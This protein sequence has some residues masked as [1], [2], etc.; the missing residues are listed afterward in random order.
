MDAQRKRDIGIAVFIVGIFA[1][2]LMFGDWPLLGRASVGPVKGVVVSV[3]GSGEGREA[4]VQLDQ[5]G[6]VRAT[7]SSGCLVLPGYAATVLRLERRIGLGPR[8][9]ILS[10][11]AK[12]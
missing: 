10:A 7:V 8:Y 2:W 5:G 4:L 6:E 3:S 1:A 12:E 9:M 11:E